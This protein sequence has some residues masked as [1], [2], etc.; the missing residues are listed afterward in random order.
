MN[1]KVFHHRLRRLCALVIGF[2]FLLA[3]IF[4]L[5]DPV[6]AGLVVEEYY[7]FLHLGFL[8]PTAKTA[9]VLLALAE[10][11][12]GAALITGVWKKVVAILTG[13]LIVFFTIITLLLAIFNPEME[14]GCFGEVIHLSNFQTLLKNIILLALAAIAF[15][16]LGSIGE[17]RKKKIIPFLIVAVS[18]AGFT[19]YSLSS[20]PMVD[21]T[22]FTPG[23][24][25]LSSK[26]GDGD[27][28]DEYTATFIYEKNGQEGAFT[29]DRLPD[30][31]WTFVRTETIK[32]NGP[33]VEDNV[34][35]LSFKDA[36]GN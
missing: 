24:E 35:I 14:C 21:Y 22:A 18:L 2:V 1:T 10:S 7:R 26:D 5:L 4:K 23:S 36:E 34:P 31:T 6:G 9:A 11:L 8:M 3:G 28:E 32:I 13:I 20:I 16:P 33:H 17:S 29:L 30:S 12:L 15:I 27:D 19:L 25:L